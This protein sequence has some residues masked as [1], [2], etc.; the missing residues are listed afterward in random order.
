MEIKKQ[1]VV[2]TI[3]KEE[4]RPFRVLQLTDIHIGGGILCFRKDRWALEAVEKVVKAADPDLIV[5]TGDMVY[6]LFWATGARNN[7]RPAKKLATLLQSLG[8]PWCF[9][10]GNHDGEVFATYT[11]EQLGEY[12]KT[13]D[14]CLYEKG[15]EGI[16]GCG[17]Y[18]IRIENKDGSPAML[19]MMVD[20]N[21]YTTK[22]FF[23]GFDVIHD[24]QIDWYKRTVREQSGD[25]KVLPSLAFF[26]IPPKEFKEAWEKCYR[27]DKSV[28]YHH[29]FVL[30]KDNYFGYPKQKKSNFFKEMVD[31]GSCKGMFM[32]HDHVNT[33][34]LTYQGIRLT[35][36]MSIDYL[37]YIGIKKK[38]TQ[39]GGTI[40]EINDDGSFDVK[41]LPLSDIK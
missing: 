15:E 6:P 17:N 18:C 21:A 12:F 41:M 27:G 14:G 30:E 31:F 25:G 19:L 10:F 13:F 11:K 28:T 26:H 33:L 5:M 35:Y 38:H 9:A 29:G 34:S 37:A 20:S 7:K 36:G 1:K 24:D 39:R 32:G 2:T 8:K 16:T 22:S 4:G 3:V 23:S 40:I